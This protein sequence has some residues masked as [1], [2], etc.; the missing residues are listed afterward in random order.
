MSYRDP[1]L[2]F[3]AQADAI[4]RQLA[5]LDELVGQLRRVRRRHP[6]GARVWTFFAGMLLAVALLGIPWLA[7]RGT[8]CVNCDEYY[9]HR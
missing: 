1:D 2:A 3:K 5:T 8:G 7:H 6:P 4:A 9:R